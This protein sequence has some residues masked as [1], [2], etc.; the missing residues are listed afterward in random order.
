MAGLA[1]PLEVGDYHAVGRSERVVD[2]LGAQHAWP[3]PGAP[4]ALADAVQ[5]QALREELGREHLVGLFWGSKRRGLERARCL[6]GG[7]QGGLCVGMC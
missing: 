1:L 7:A 4:V 2:D 6:I 5:G 3:P